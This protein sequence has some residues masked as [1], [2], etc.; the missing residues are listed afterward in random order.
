MDKEQALKNLE[1]KARAA[2]RVYAT[3]DGR[4]LIDALAEEMDKE[5]LRGKDTH[6]TYFNLGRR[7]SITY[8]R[9][10]LSLNKRIEDAKR[11]DHS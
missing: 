9:E 4:Y 8:I 7:D 1:R 3:E 5:D 2:A 6:E 11:G 10:L